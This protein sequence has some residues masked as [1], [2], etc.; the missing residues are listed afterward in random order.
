MNELVRIPEGESYGDETPDDLIETIKD[1]AKEARNA[2]RDWLTEA[3]ECY[4]FVAG[5]QWT[6]EEME[7]LRAQ[8][9]QTQAEEA[10][11]R[12]AELRQRSGAGSLLEVLD[13][14]RSVFAARQAAVLTELAQY[15]NGVALYKALGGGAL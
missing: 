13:A 9:A 4:D 1:C 11:L 7:Q 3:Q 8:R 14:Q 5:H 6:P 12:L 2:R 15:Q 10:R